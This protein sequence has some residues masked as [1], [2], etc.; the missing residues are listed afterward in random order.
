MLN[1]SLRRIQNELAQSIHELFVPP[2]VSFGID[3]ESVVGVR[4]AVLEL[5]QR[6]LLR[7]RVVRAHLRG[8]RIA[9]PDEAAG[10]LRRDPGDVGAGTLSWWWQRVSRILP[11]ATMKPITANGRP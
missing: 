4:L 8:Y 5:P 9:K 2:K 3:S 7:L 10:T 11:S 6:E 1:P